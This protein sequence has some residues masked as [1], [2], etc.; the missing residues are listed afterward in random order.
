M[1]VETH[2]YIK[3]EGVKGMIAERKKEKEI[4]AK[5]ISEEMAKLQTQ[6]KKDLSLFPMTTNME[7][8]GHE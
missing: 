3:G 5:I 4:R 8:H 2:E 6:N 1:P 7:I